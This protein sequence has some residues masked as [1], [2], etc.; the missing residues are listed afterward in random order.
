MK[1][2]SKSKEAVVEPFEVKVLCFLALLKDY[3]LICFS[4]TA[5][6]I[7][8]EVSEKNE[9]LTFILCYIYIKHNIYIINIYNKS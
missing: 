1:H 3:S 9:H 7:N 2:P 6:D 5:Y 4:E 8:V